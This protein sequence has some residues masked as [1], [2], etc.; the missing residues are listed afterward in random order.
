VG[1]RGERHEWADHPEL[2]TSLRTPWDKFRKA[3]WNFSR[4]EDEL[5]KR[6]CNFE[7]VSFAALDL[8]VALTSL[9]DW[10]KKALTR[11]VR[12]G[13]RDLPNGLIKL[14][15]WPSYID[16]KI[17]WMSAIEAI[18]NTTKHAEY[19]DIGWPRGIAMLATFVPPNLSDEKDACEDGLALFGFMHR[20]RDVAWWD[21]ALRQHGDHEA[22]PGYEAFGDALEAWEQLLISC[23]FKSE[24]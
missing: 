2:L 6:P 20:Y 17:P 23:G 21:I 4:Y 5:F 1:R 19:R 11:D 22:T 14:D 3:D 12:A 24:D 7:N 9:R 15:D 10:T 13:V 16:R 18:A 8:C